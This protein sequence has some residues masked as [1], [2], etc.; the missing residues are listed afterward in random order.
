MRQLITTFAALQLH[1]NSVKKFLF[2]VEPAVVLSGWTQH[3]TSTNCWWVAW[4]IGPADYSDTGVSRVLADGVALTVRATLSLCNSNASSYFLDTAAQRLYVHAADSGTPADYDVL[5]RFWQCFATHGACVFTFSGGLYPGIYKPIIAA[6]GIPAFIARDDDIVDSGSEISVGTMRL[7]NGKNRDYAGGGPLDYSLQHF[8]YPRSRCRCLIGGEQLPYSEYQPYWSGQI[9]T[10]QIESGSV[11]LV[12]KD[13]TQALD[14]KFPDDIY[15]LN[16]KALYEFDAGALTTDS[17]G[18]GHTLTAIGYPYEDTGLFNGCVVLDANDA[19]SIA[20]HAHFKPTVP[21]EIT[22]WVKKDGVPGTFVVIAQ[23][24]ARA[25]DVP[26]GWQLGIDGSGYVYFQTFKNTGATLHTDYE[27]VRGSADICDDEWHQIAASWNGTHLQLAVDGLS[28][29][30]PVAWANAPAYQATNYVRIGCR[31][32]TGTNG[33]FFIGSLD[34]TYLVHEK[35]QPNAEGATIPTIYGRCRNVK[36]QQ[37]N[38][39]TWIFQ[40]AS[41]E[42]LALT[43]VREAGIDITASNIAES[44]LP[45]ATFRLYPYADGKTIT[46]DV[47]GKPTGGVAIDTYAGIALELLQAAPGLTADDIDSTAFAAFDA[48]CPQ[49]LGVYID[50]ATPLRTTLAA[51]NKSVLCRIVKGRNGKLRPVK[52]GMP[53]ETGEATFTT[54]T[55]EGLTTDISQDKL[56]YKVR[57]GWEKNWTPQPDT[58][59]GGVAVREDWTHDYRWVEK[60]NAATKNRYACEDTLIVETLLSQQADAEALAAEYL[61][62]LQ[63]PWLLISFTAP[64]A[65]YTLEIGD[66]IE[67]LDSRLFAAGSLF[68]VTGLQDDPNTAKVQ[69]SAKAPCDGT[70]TLLVAEPE[71]M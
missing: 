66:T 14:H 12:I 11:G 20:D 6:G 3:P 67:V 40:L 64:V 39:W 28:A 43:A 35:L 29:R 15:Q 62:M 27:E 50:Q 52:F 37:V 46:C 48:T 8:I 33:N 36:P 41:H 59:A 7:C 61:A 19:Y 1:K 63:Q 51:M 38:V 44:S 70:M 34:R 58:A 17:S 69:I 25:G 54:A 47:V 42:L 53:A 5:A 56:Y 23:S 45:D 22:A 26:A 21:F 4:I 30:S 55:I 16:R 68:L 2:E 60:T 65:P 24:F 13:S 10:V 32:A 31:N 18:N 9:A 57:L 71:V 49:K